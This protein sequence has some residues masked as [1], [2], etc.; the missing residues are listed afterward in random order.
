MCALI[1]YCLGF[2]FYL[3]YFFKRE[4]AIYRRLFSTQRNFSDAFIKAIFWPFYAVVHPF[5]WVWDTYSEKVANWYIKTW[6]IKND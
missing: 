1:V 6:N 5:I 3:A 4:M 2:Y